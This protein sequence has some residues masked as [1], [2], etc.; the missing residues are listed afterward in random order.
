MSHYLITGAQGGS[1]KGADAPNRIEI[2][3]FVKIPNQFSLYIQALTEMFNESQPTSTSHFGIGGI[4]GLPPVQWEGA[5]GTQPIPGSGWDGYCT[6]GSVLFPTWHRP[7]VALYE[8]VMQSHALDIAGKYQVDQDSWRTAALNLRAPY[9]DW[10]TNTVPPP[11][12]VSLQTVDIITFDGTTITVPNP[13]YQYTFH[14]ID[15]SFPNR[16]SSWKTTIR[17]PDDP[18]SPNATTDVQALIDVLTSIQDGITSSVYHL[19]MLVHTWPAFSNHTSGD[20]DS[21]SSS[22]EAIHDGIHY[23]IGGQMADTAVAGFDP[24]FFLHHANVDRLLS[25]WA[26]VNP[27]VW[28]TPGPADAGS[29]TIPRDATIDGNTDLSPFWNAQ[30]GFWVSSGTTTTAGLNYTYPEFNGL[31]MSDPAGVQQAI[32]GY[33]NQQYGESGFSLFRGTGPALSFLAQQPAAGSAP[34]PAAPSAMPVAAAVSA[35]KSVAK[36]LR[37]PF[38]S[39]GGHPHTAE[40]GE[41]GRGGPNVA[42]VHDWTVRVHFKKYELGQSFAVLIFLGEVPDDASRWR[43]C[44]SFVGAHV[45]FVNSAADQC[46]NCRQQADVVSE[47]FVHLNS[48]IA[49]RSGLSSYEPNVVTPYLRDNLHWRI[50]GADRTAIAVERL[51]SL[52]VN[53]VQTTLTQE[54]GSVFP[55]AGEPHYHHHITHGRPGGARHA[56]A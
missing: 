42:S 24:I 38:A 30:T 26:A 45:A 7:Y 18:N 4:H 49:R 51:P 43:T 36:E 44:P 55:I 22:L 5:G 2:N 32:S 53:V 54:P 56:Q 48:T 8:Q 9:W 33:I 39:R 20:G 3:D 50:Q 16:Y 10:A 28:V 52:E 1:T 11:E 14:P 12:V 15:S 47:G 17:H 29:W 21:S 31:N 27:G 37:H 25:L 46:G 34:A 23:Y 35:I 19:L 13:L 6:H 41:H 40:S